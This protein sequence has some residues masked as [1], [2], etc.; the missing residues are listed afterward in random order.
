MSLIIV[1]GARLSGKSFLVGS[2]KIY[3]V[4]KFD[5]NGAFS[6]LDFQKNSTDAHYLGLGKELMLQQLNHFG[7]FDF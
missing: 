6:G 7:F 5:F 3:P 2:Q 4:F 1:E